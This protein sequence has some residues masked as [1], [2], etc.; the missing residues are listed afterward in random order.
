[1]IDAEGVIRF[2]IDEGVSS[3]DMEYIRFHHRRFAEL[4]SMAADPSTLVLDVGPGFQT[5]LLRRLSPAERVIDTLGYP[6]SGAGEGR[7]GDVHYPFDL[8]DSFYPDRWPSPR[9]RYDLIIA[10]EVIEH[11]YTSPVDVFSFLA[12]FLSPGGRLLVQ[13]PNACSAIKRI[14][15][16]KGRYP[17][18]LVRQRDNAP[19][20]F[21]EYSLEELR[22]CGAEAGLGVAE[23]RMRNYFSSD[24]FKHRFLAAVTDFL[25]GGLRAG[26]TIVYRFPR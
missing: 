16:L 14:H 19:Y 23:Y 5:R 11:L 18:P 13:T 12:T 4:L 2:F 10:A 26:I 3:G 22:I 15:M 8:N 25:P 9:R 20:H 24:R 6:S 21:R 1:M 7:P 17:F